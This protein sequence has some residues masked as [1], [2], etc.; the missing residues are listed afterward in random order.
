MKHTNF[1]IAL[2]VTIVVPCLL[3]ARIR[4][5]DRS[6]YI[7]KAVK[8]EQKSAEVVI[9]ETKKVN[10]DDITASKLSSLLDE[11]TSK[12]SKKNYADIV[13]LIAEVIESRGIGYMNKATATAHDAY[14]FVVKAEKIVREEKF[15]KDSTELTNFKTLLTNLK[16]NKLTPPEKAG[17]AKT[18]GL[19]LE[20][21]IKN[22]YST[23]VWG[24]LDGKK[25]MAEAENTVTGFYTTYEIK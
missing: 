19:S 11:S 1:F 23:A 15:A 14:K 7:S 17:E 6:W 16:N 8:L 5:E 10:R 13:G 4:E 21:S 18:G 24:L 22:Y 20:E 2:V 25:K 9:P 3:V 12:L